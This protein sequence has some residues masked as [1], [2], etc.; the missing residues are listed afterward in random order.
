[1]RKKCINTLTHGNCAFALI[2]STRRCR[3]VFFFLVFCVVPTDSYYIPKKSNLQEAMSTR[4]TRAKAAAASAAQAAQTQSQSA[5]D[6]NSSV[7]VPVPSLDPP[8]NAVQAEKENR[9]VSVGT[10]KA[11]TNG[12]GVG[13][14]KSSKKV[15]VYCTCKREDDGTPMIYCGECKDWC[16][17]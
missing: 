16:V 7:S 3:V 13:A 15:D 5:H 6:S 12:K 1:M 9:D 2:Q 8:S 14:G 17:L 4:T 11:S 10:T